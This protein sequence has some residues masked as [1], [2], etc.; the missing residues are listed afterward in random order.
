M[1]KIKLIDVR[2]AFCNSMWPGAEE[3]FQGAGP[4]RHSATFLVE[5]GSEN[6]K[7]I[8]AAILEAAKEK[9]TKPGQAEKQIAALKGNSNKY[10][11]QSGDLKD[12]D[13]FQGMMALSSHRKATDGAP[14]IL[15][16]NKAPLAQNSG[17]L[18]GGCYVDAVIDIYAQAGEFSGIRSGL[19]GVQFRRTG[20]SFGGAGKATEDDFEDLG[21]GA[22]AEDFA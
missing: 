11:Y 7:K 6:D 3:Q 16:S 13:G 2:I 14:T 4:F 18:F 1:A 19:R 17:K 22:D 21:Q 12:Y 5:P 15:D 9:W 8:N 20:D 10:C